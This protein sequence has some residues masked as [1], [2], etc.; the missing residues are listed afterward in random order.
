[1]ATKTKTYDCIAAKRRSHE[2]LMREYEAS[3]DEF[4]SPVEFLNAKAPLLKIT[5]DVRA[6][7]VSATETREA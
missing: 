6:K 1:M 2:R 4:T 3:K 5:L 7:I